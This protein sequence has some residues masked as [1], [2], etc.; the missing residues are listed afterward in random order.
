MRHPFDTRPLYRIVFDGDVVAEAYGSDDSAFDSLIA[1]T[2]KQMPLGIVRTG[3][4]SAT[5][6]GGEPLVLEVA[7]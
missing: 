1:W 6:A 7:S 3:P 2:N 4:R 5:S